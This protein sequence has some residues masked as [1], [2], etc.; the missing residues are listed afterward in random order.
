MPALVKAY[1]LTIS[2]E[3]ISFDDARALKTVNSLQ[4]YF[5]AT[6]VDVN[7]PLHQAWMAL[8]N[9]Y[10]EGKITQEQFEK[11]KDELTAPIEFK[12]PETGQMVTFTEEYA[13]KINDRIAT[14]AGFQSQLMDE[15]RS[16][17]QEKYNKVLEELKKITG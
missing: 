3:G 7:G 9:A 10:K 15:W 5:K 4:Y 11:L 1:E 17:A 12:D 13:A 2:S 6:L 16:A 14:D 8:V